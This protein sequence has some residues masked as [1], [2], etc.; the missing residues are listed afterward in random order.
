MRV[1]PEQNGEKQLV[2]VLPAIAVYQQFVQPVS[3]R[4]VAAR[5]AYMP[6]GVGR[7]DLESLGF[8]SIS[9]YTNRPRSA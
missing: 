6:H 9:A 4:Q 5:T 1:D 3:K 2:V 8:K 7:F